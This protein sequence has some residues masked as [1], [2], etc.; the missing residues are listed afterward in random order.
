MAT[1]ATLIVVPALLSLTQY[2][3]LCMPRGGEG[4]IRAVAECSK[5]PVIKHYKG[6]CHVFVDRDAD[7]AM[8]NLESPLAND[9]PVLNSWAGDGTYWV[10]KEP[11]VT[12]YWFVTY[13]SVFGDD[14]NPAVNAHSRSK[15]A[16]VRVLAGATLTIL[17]GD[18]QKR[19]WVYSVRAQDGRKGWIP[20]RSLRLKR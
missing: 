6:V 15:G 18:Y 10:T 7:L 12:N 13:A 17:D 14:P 5:V 9:T 20:E 4:L 3:D 8:A 19:G 1:L 16:E 11:M 2:V